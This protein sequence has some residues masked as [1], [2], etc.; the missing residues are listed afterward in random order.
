VNVGARPFGGRRNLF[1]LLVYTVE[2]SCLSLCLTA[3]HHTGAQH[4]RTL[5]LAT[6]PGLTTPAQEPARGCLEAAAR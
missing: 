2:T 1:L 3:T 5:S 6:I 4:T